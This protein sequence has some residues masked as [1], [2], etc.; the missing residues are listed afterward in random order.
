MASVNVI[1]TAHPMFQIHARNIDPEFV[2]EV[3]LN[4]QQNVAAPGGRQ[5]RQTQY[6]DTIEQKAM[7]LRVLVEAEAG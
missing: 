4:P 7:L 5:V 3:A 2:R 1:I 6:F